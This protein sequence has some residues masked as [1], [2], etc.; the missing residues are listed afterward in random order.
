MTTFDREVDKLHQNLALAF[1]IAFVI[2]LALSVWLA[3]SITQPLSNI[4]IAHNSWRRVTMRSA[5]G[6]D[7]GMKSAS[8]PTR[9]IT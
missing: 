8:W 2:A 3:R 5:F 6:P 7:H 9:S 4:A 1:G